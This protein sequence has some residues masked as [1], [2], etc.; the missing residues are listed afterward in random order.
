MLE[1][2]NS[3]LWELSC[4]EL[5]LS[6]WETLDA[7]RENV[8][9]RPYPWR[10]RRIRRIKDIRSYPDTVMDYVFE[11][12]WLLSKLNLRP[13]R[14]WGSCANIKRGS[15]DQICTKVVRITSA[16][17][18]LSP[19]QQTRFFVSSMVKD[20]FPSRTSRVGPFKIPWSKQNEEN[21]SICTDVESQQQVSSLWSCLPRRSNLGSTCRATQ[22]PHPYPTPWKLMPHPKMQ[23][24]D[25]A[26]KITFVRFCWVGSKPHTAKILCGSG[27]RLTKASAFP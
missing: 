6:K 2:N 12:S 1:K 20:F 19:P 11:P 14:K 4:F 17:R 16:L 21:S 24:L 18:L 25:L 27:S 22:K 7:W 9:A 3:R 26:R 23:G 15:Q 10:I 13:Y 8:G 5:F